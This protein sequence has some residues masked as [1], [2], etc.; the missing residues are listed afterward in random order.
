MV[1]SYPELVCVSSYY[2]PSI[3]LPIILEGYF[4]SKLALIRMRPIRL[5]EL[6]DIQTFEELSIYP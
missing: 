1:N 6:C 4:T 3:I 5:E 2:L